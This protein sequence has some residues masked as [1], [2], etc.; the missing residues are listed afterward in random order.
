[1]V[2]TLDFLGSLKPEEFADFVNERDWI[3]KFL[4]KRIK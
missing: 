3:S 4:K 1:M 2:E